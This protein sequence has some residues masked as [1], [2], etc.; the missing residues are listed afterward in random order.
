[1]FSGVI[2]VTIDSRQGAEVIRL[3]RPKTVSGVIFLIRVEWNHV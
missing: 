1:M 3:V 2:I